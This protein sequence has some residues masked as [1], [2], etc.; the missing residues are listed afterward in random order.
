MTT[1]Q[2]LE[3]LRLRVRF[4]ELKGRKREV[5]DGSSPDWSRWA[6]NKPRRSPA[7]YA[8]GM[9]PEYRTASFPDG[10]W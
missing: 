3:A 6:S 1:A 5:A 2:Q 9:S 7:S 4:L 10:S 8:S